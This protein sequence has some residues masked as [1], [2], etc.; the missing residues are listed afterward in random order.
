MEGYWGSTPPPELVKSD[1][2]P[3]STGKKKK[4]KASPSG[5]IPEYAPGYNIIT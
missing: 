3:P 1:P 4:I 5:Q 2:R